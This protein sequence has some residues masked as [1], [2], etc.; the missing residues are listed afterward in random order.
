VSVERL[1]IIGAQAEHLALDADALDLLFRSALARGR[2]LR[3]WRDLAVRRGLTPALAE[4]WVA[5]LEDEA[6]AG[7]A[8]TLLTS[9]SDAAAVSWLVTFIASQS[10]RIRPISL[11]KLLHSQRRALVALAQIECPEAED[12][13]RGLTPDGFCFVPAGYLESRGDRESEGRKWL[14]AF[15]I[16]RSPVTMDDWA[17]FVEAGGY[18][19]KRYWRRFDERR[20]G[21]RTVLTGWTVGTGRGKN[22]VCDVTWDEAMAYARWL[23]ETTGLP[24]DL[25]TETEWDRASSWDPAIKQSMERACHAHRRYWDPNR[26]LLLAGCWVCLRLVPLKGQAEAVPSATGSMPH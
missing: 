23:A 15:A 4:R 8:V 22:P 21:R 9:L 3:L 17:D 13:L 14:N 10:S 24:V 19:E 25:P 16:A 20:G 12:Y 11:G 18:R 6:R 7:I 5:G 1:D 2:S 26:T